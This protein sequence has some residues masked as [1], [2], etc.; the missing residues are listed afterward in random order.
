MKSILGGPSEPRRNNRI[1]DTKSA[2]PGE[3]RDPDHKSRCRSAR[4]GSAYFLGSTVGAESYD[5]DPG[6]RRDE[7]KKNGKRTNSSTNPWFAK[8][9]REA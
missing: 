7:R 2:H 4:P 6:I 9:G 1:G 8:F 3:C 5:L